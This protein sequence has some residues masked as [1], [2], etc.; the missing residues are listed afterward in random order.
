MLTV[1]GTDVALS[2]SSFL[3]G[4]RFVV[5]SAVRALERNVKLGLL[6]TLG[7]LIANL[8]EVVCK[9][10]QALFGSTENT[11]IAMNERLLFIG[12]RCFASLA[13]PG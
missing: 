10:G 6:R 12:R 13:P 5:S 7:A 2:K 3:V 8:Q 1:H 4:A 9:S 11:F